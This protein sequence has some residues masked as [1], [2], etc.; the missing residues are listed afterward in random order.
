MND[1]GYLFYLLEES[2]NFPKLLVRIA[3]IKRRKGGSLNSD[4]ES[5]LNYLMHE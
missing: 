1:Y 4:E 2:R 5:A 3:E